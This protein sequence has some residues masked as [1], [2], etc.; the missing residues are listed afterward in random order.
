MQTTT[1]SAPGIVC[2]GCASSIQRALGGIPGVQNVQVDIEAKTV[3]VTHDPAQAP[4][5]TLAA[6]LDDAGFSVAA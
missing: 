5:E 2:G 3:T 4:R 1:F 6:A